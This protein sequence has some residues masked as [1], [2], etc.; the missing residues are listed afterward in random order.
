MTNDLNPAIGDFDELAEDFDRTRPVCPAALFDDL[1]SLAALSPGDRVV[2]IC[3]GSGQATVPLA[4]RGLAVTAIEIG[5]K[6][7]A[8]ARRRL[9]GFPAV[10]VV[11]SS[12]EDWGPDGRPVAAVVAFNALHWIAPEGRYAKPA[13]L[14]GLGGVMVVGGCTWA[15]PENAEPFWREVQQDYWAV[16]YEGA[17]PPPPEGIA[18]WSFPEEAA[19]YFEEVAARR[20]PFQIVYSAEEY[21][22]MLATQS[23]TR[24]LGAARRREFLDSVRLRLDRRPRLTASFVGFLTVGKR[25]AVAEGS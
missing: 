1:L 23:G 18:P 4:E 8:I 3:C 22:A 12:F 15:L 24:A 2:E 7:A 9:S 21:L 20:Y 25:N 11:T 16:G 13:A 10:E 6:L 19:L 17:P 5:V 14:L